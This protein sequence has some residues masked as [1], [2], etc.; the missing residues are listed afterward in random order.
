MCG[1]GDDFQI[2]RAHT[3]A[4]SRTN[5]TQASPADV[6]ALIDAD[7]HEWRTA[8]GDTRRECGD[9]GV[10]ALLWRLQDD[11]IDQGATL[12]GTLLNIPHVNTL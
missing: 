1:N 6:T 5:Y 8:P 2:P 9:E 4:R 10:Q 11:S 7:W 3:C 12:P